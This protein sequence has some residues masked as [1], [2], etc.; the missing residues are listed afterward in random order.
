M[1]SNEIKF[2]FQWENIDEESLES[3]FNKIGTTLNIYFDNDLNIY[4]KNMKKTYSIID[5]SDWKE[6]RIEEA[7][8]SFLNFSFDE[9]IDVPL[10]KFL[11]LKNNSDKYRY[12]LLANIHSSIFDYTS[13][14]SFYELFK[15]FND[16][17]ISTSNESN[18]KKD[19]LK[20][21]I[22]SHH[23]SLNKYLNSTDFEKDSQYWKQFQLDIGDNVKYYNLES[24]NYKNIKIPIDNEKLSNFLK[25]NDTSKYN[26]ILSIFSLYLSRVDRTN[27]CLL[28][29]IIPNN[30][31]EFSPFDKDT[32]LNIKYYKENSFID[33][34]NEI[35]T[36]FNDSEKYTKADI[37]NYIKE[38]LSFYSIY[39][40]S[41]LEN[42]SILFW[43]DTLQF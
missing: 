40:F 12:T 9:A 1:K 34:L 35:E 5:V 30:E 31:N 14:K 26:F 3:F 28:K 4:T 13:I 27:G 38:E 22:I 43:Q 8:S 24:S 23:N 2:K 15:K 10:F 11:I 19:S 16:N 41:E 39:D 33:Y 18:P 21:L 25:A 32:L 29:T 17:R 37:G 42:M 6:E 7:M 20:D 36:V